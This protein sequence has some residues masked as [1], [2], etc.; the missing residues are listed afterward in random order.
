MLRQK[1]I[2]IQGILVFLSC[3]LHAL[4]AAGP[5][6]TDSMDVF[7]WHQFVFLSCCFFSFKKELCITMHHDIDNFS[8]LVA[9][10]ISFCFAA[11]LCYVDD[12][13]DILHSTLYLALFSCC[14][15]RSAFRLLLRQF[16]SPH[17]HSLLHHIISHY[18]RPHHMFM[19]LRN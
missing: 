3:T 15:L 9:F 6:F 7:K 11:L 18:R 13:G 4:L 12:A 17:M 10:R 8:F 1:V 5:I 16:C 14:A 2:E 19:A